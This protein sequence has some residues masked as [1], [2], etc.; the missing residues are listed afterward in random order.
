M[1]LYMHDHK[2]DDSTPFA[3]DVTLDTWRRNIHSY[4]FSNNLNFDKMLKY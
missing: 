4:K 3:H 1:L 2:S